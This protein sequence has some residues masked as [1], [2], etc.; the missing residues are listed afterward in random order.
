MQNKILLACFFLAL[1][2]LSNAEFIR[3][4]YITGTLSS[5]IFPVQTFQASGNPLP[6]IPKKIN[7]TDE[8]IIKLA[9]QAFNGSNSNLGILLLDK[10]Q[11]VYK[12][13]K[14]SLDENTKFFSYSM[15]KSLTAYTIGVSLCSGVIN[16]LDDKV[17]EYS[18][19]LS[20]SIFG[21]ST[22]RNLLTM[23]SG[24]RRPDEDGGSLNGEWRDLTR[25]FKS[26][27]EILLSY[28]IDEANP[29][30]FVYNNSDTNALM[31]AVNYKNSFSETF[32]QKIW[33]KSR[34][35]NSSTWLTDKK[36]NIYAAAGFGASILDWGRLALHSI[37]MRNGFEDKC[38]AEFMKNATKIQIHDQNKK[39]FYGY[40]YQTWIH[41]KQESQI[42]LW[43]GTYGQ[44]VIIDPVNEKVLVLFRN[45]DDKSTTDQISKLFWRWSQLQ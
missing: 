15:S 14:N 17:S 31:L 21:R 33:L 5:G 32:N 41:P 23:S 7:P 28:G 4:D 12:K 3:E 26:I 6:L 35:Q 34:P 19:L 9:E 1:P 43:L 10:N 42:Y 29:G 37:K 18:P 39:R 44:R 25:G 16:S 27:D 40:G 13:F 2:S 22:I 45:E 30:S 36:G 11:V 8:Q 20:N 38:I 24:A